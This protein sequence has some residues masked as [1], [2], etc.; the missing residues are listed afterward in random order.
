[1]WGEGPSKAPPERQGAPLSPQSVRS[2]ANEAKQRETVSSPASGR[3]FEDRSGAQEPPAAGGA[4][5]EGRPVRGP[6][7]LK[8]TV[9][10][11]RNTG[12]VAPGV[13]AN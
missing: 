6:I 2:P 12:R 5:A 8:G 11:H 4:G 1:M 7:W 13:G 3:Y 10:S 9:D